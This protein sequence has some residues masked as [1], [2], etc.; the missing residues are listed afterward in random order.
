[1]SQTDQGQALQALLGN[2][3]R[4][5]IQ[6][7]TIKS[8]GPLTIL[9]DKPSMHAGPQDAVAISQARSADSR[10]TVTPQWS[11][12]TAHIKLKNDL[13]GTL[14]RVTVRHQRGLNAGV[15]TAKTWENVN[16]GDTTDVFSTDFQ[17]GQWSFGA[18]IKG[19][20][21]N[22]SRYQASFPTMTI[23]RSRFS[24]KKAVPSSRTT[25]GSNAI[26]EKMV[27]GDSD[28]ERFR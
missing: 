7:L 24:S 2:L 8:Y 20:S 17:E 3:S 15:V 16:P 9:S 25:G 14:R 28:L 12:E 19:M 11:W 18:S 1:M 6:N 23:G 26:C 5:T 4:Y 27:I 10:D 21:T 22:E 13:E